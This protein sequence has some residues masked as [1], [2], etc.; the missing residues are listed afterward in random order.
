MTSST[1]ERNIE[2]ARTGYQAFNEGHLDEAMATIHDEI[3]WHN[4]GDNPITGD[5]RG[6]EAVMQMLATFG[7]LT[8]GTY[9]ADIHDILASD[10]HTVVIGTYTAT[11]HG[12]TR[13]ARF[14]D[15]VHPAPDGRAKEFWRFFD[16]QAAEDEFLKE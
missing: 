6:K 15:V 4:G 14:V 13:S 3:L 11:R 9:E 10:E 8:E 5:F 2:M 16:D 12:R 1:A 7:Q